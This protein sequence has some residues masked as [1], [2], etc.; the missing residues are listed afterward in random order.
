[1]SYTLGELA[2]AT[3]IELRGDAS[4]TIDGVGS[5]TNA[6][7]TQ[8]SFCATAKYRKLLSDSPAGAMV[9]SPA[10]AD[11][12]D[13]LGAKLISTDPYLTFTKISR[14]LNPEPIARPGIHPT[15]VVADSAVIDASAEVGPHAVIGAD[16]ELGSGVIIGASCVIGDNCQI[17]DNCRL[18]PRVVLYDRSRVGQRTIL[19]SGVVLGADGF[20]LAKEGDRWL[21]T[22]QLGTVE[23]GD[24]VEIGAN[25]T[26]D[27]GAMEDTIIADGVKLDN[28]IQVGHGVQ[29]GTNTAIAACVGVSGSTKIGERTMI[30]GG[31]GIGGHLEIA[32][33]TFVAGLSM[34][35]RSINKPGS[36]AGIPLTDSTTWRR[37]MAQLRKLDQLAKRLRKLEKQVENEKSDHESD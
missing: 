33:D 1:M 17:G 2:T 18:H 25:T 34:V 15:A 12:S 13:Y 11:A 32:S 27:R 37:N 31:T 23:I 10:D 6:G 36:Y 21:K 9:L 26:I 7:P 5:L 16:S 29:I 20:G 8:V 24:D 35:S 30:A 28:Q 19:H 14:L 22:P 4:L 3:D